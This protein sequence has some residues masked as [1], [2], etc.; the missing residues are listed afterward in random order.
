MEWGHC[1]LVSK[2]NCFR[3]NK[4]TMTFPFTVVLNFGIGNSKWAW[5][6][7]SWVRQKSANL[8]THSNN[9]RKLISKVY[10]SSSLVPVDG[11]HMAY[12]VLEGGN[13]LKGF[14]WT[15]TSST[16]SY[17]YRISILYKLIML[18]GT[19]TVIW[20]FFLRETL[21]RTW[22]IVSKS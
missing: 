21:I 6:R 13:V 18:T 19:F 14:S 20:T 2:N 22:K 5:S 16:D 4:N 7:R 17:P 10:A 11:S 9:P 8:A 15:K 12:R 1:S 3:N